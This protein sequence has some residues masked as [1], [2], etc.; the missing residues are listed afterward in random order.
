LP[1]LSRDHG[2][3]AALDGSCGYLR[4]STPQALDAVSPEHN[5]TGRPLR[6]RHTAIAAAEH[7][8]MDA[9]PDTPSQQT[10]TT[11]TQRLI[12]H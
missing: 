5:D 8:I 3:L 9:M 10:R 7:A 4:Q 11:V 1:P 12:A 2:H 6:P